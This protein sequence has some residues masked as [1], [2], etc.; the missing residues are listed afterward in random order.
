MYTKIINDLEKDLKHIELKESSNIDNYENCTKVV[1]NCINQL[2]KKVITNDF[3]K[4]ED[5]IHFFKKVKPQVVSKFIYYARLFQ[6][7]SKRP[8]G[9]AKTQIAYF[10]D[11]IQ[12]CQN[13]FNKS[14]QFYQYFRSGEHYFDQQYFL[15]K[16]KSIR[17]QFDCSGSFIDDQFSTSL[18]ST[19]SK[20][21][22]YESLI[23]TFQNE[24]E[25]LEVKR[26]RPFI[27]KLKWT[28]KKIDLVELIYSL[29]EQKV[30]NNGNVGIKE[31]ASYTEAAFNVKLGDYYRSFQEIKMRNN[32]TKF[33]DSLK[34]NILSYIQK[35]DK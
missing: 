33:I 6:V 3:L 22:A 25:K 9:N 34:N 12:K 27:S 8:K 2:R 14:H 4:N 35:S 17:I 15:R 18:D 20:L 21:I 1:Q 7:E 13:Y 5:E 32:K 16:N 23:D 31:I 10:D 26:G 30:F 11:E 24:I 19:F 29:V 28:G